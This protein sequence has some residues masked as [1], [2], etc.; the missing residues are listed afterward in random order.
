MSGFQYV[1][2]VEKIAFQVQDTENNDEEEEQRV[3][4]F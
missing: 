1:Y 3:Q 2:R 4:L